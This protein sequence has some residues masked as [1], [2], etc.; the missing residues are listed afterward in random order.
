MKSVFVFMVGAVASQAFCQSSFRTIAPDAS[1]DYAVVQDISGNGRF[2]LVSQQNS[3]PRDPL[4][5]YILDLISGTRVN[6]V[7]EYGRDLTP[8]GIS[9]DGSRVVGYLGGGPLATTVAFLW[10]AEEGLRELG[11][12]AGANIN[13]AKSLSADGSVV[14][15]TSGTSFGDMYQQGWRWTA[16]A[17]FEALTDLGPDTLDFGSAENISADGSTIVGMGSLGDQ[18]PD[19]DD[20]MSAVIWQSSET[21]PTNLGNL[22]SLSYTGGAMCT[23][24]SGDGAVV[25]GFSPAISTS[26]GFVTHGFRWT[27]AQ[28]LVDIGQLASNPQGSIYILDC[29]RDGETLVG[30][31]IDGGVSSWQAVVWS[32]AAGVQTLRSMLNARGVVVPANLGLRETYC[33]ADASVIGGWAYNITTGKYVGYVAS[34]PPPCSA[35]FNQDGG[36]DG[37]DVEAFFAQWEAGN[38]TGDTNRDGGVDGGDIEFFF[39]QWEAGGC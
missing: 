25:V 22:P 10:D 34:F 8:I 31:M 36:V 15:G 21:T 37:A 5:G 17:G 23:A 7:D 38:P 29:S 30:Y 9:D 24:A 12:L 6:L 33:S 18:D 39:T 35:D 11:G 28:G 4:N 3:V 16:E 20:L 26:G 14:V 32:A 1:F 27:Q 13:Y 2:A 19:T